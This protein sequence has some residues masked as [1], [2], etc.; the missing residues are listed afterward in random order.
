MHLK[1]LCQP[2]S[3]LFAPLVNR[4]CIVFFKR[5]ADVRVYKSETWTWSIRWPNK[6]LLLSERET[7]FNYYSSNLI[8]NW[9]MPHALIINAIIF[10]LV[11]HRISHY[12]VSRFSPTAARCTMA[13]GENQLVILMNN[14]R[15]ELSAALCEDVYLFAFRTR[16]ATRTSGEGLHAYNSCALIELQQ[17]RCNFSYKEGPLTKNGPINF[18]QSWAIYM[19]KS[20]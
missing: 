6:E 1:T 4:N 16:A 11:S 18:A 13:C 12:H 9:D 8:T 10:P 15:E 7:R 2:W 5:R 20:N 19:K 14:V 3:N 17:R